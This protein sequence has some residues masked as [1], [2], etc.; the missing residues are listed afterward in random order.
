MIIEGIRNLL[1][2]DLAKQ[3]E[4]A[5]KGK[6]KDDWEAE[7]LIALLQEAERLCM[8]LLEVR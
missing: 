2:E 7:E 1:G 8:D 6:G 5:L 3:V 4:T